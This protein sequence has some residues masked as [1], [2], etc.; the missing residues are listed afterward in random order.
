[1]GASDDTVVEDEDEDKPL[2]DDAAG[3][4]CM[5]TLSPCLTL[6]VHAVTGGYGS[7]DV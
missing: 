2:N 1:M 6:V 4:T 7:T 3:T 5:V